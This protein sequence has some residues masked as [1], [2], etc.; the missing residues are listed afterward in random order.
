M[1]LRTMD[2]LLIPLA[3]TVAAALAVFYFEKASVG[4]SHQGSFSE[5]NVPSPMSRILSMGPACAQAVGVYN[6]SKEKKQLQKLKQ[7]AE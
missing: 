3:T 7:G 1:K 2:L 5:L 6:T 4:R